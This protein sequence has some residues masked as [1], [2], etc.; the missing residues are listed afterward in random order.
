[1][2]LRSLL[3][4][5]VALLVAL[6]CVGQTTVRSVRLFADLS[7]DDGG[8]EVRVEYLL[9]VEGQPPL[10]FELLGFGAATAEAFWLGERRTGTPI[11]LETESGTL[12]AADFTLTVADTGA[13]FRIDATYWIASAVERDGAEIRVRVPV[14]TLALPPA[15]GIP[16]LFRAELRLPS[17]WAVSE[18]FPT[19]LRSTDDGAFAVELAAAP[20][21]VSLRARTDGA[22]RPGLPFVLEVLTGLILGAFGVFGWRHLRKVAA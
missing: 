20:S 14:L 13:D 2:G 7:P 21:V 9:A 18:S 11:R 22:W 16:G 17:G 3:I 4:A 6:P 5:S 12:R 8:A 10:R 1:M 19:G 15:S